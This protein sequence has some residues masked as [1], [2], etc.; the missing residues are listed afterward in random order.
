MNM[1]PPV[2]VEHYSRPLGHRLDLI[3]SV[4]SAGSSLNR[5]SVGSAGHATGIPKVVRGVDKLDCEKECRH[6]LLLPRLHSDVVP[7]MT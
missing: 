3:N 2:A 5:A 4:K 7:C 6:T 1:Q